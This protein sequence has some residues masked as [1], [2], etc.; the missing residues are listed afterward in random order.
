VS[1]HVAVALGF[2]ALAVAGAE[3]QG[4]SPLVMPG[5]ATELGV[6][7]SLGLGAALA[8]VVLA[9]SRAL[10]RSEPRRAWVHD[11]VEQLDAG[12]SASSASTGGVV[13]VAAVAA[14]SEELFFR[15]LVLPFAGVVL[16]SL[17]FG[18]LHLR[19]RWTWAVAAFALALALGAIVQSTGS[20]AGALLAHVLVNVLNVPRIRAVRAGE[21]AR[22]RPGAL[23]RRSGGR[24]LGGLL[25]TK[26]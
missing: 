24:P 3:L 5:G 23:G 22:A 15:G 8:A 20:L 12:L 11:W 17:L 1:R 9:A 7:A 19:A 6:A 10:L 16:S 26:S 18:A 2:A 21:H 4:R 25:R 14:V 13:A